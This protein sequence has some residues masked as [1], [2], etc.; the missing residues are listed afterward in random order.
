MAAIL[1]Q[2]ITASAG[3]DA[4][5]ELGVLLVAAPEFDL[6]EKPSV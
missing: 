5:D 2:V 3:D 6:G 1:E 4:L